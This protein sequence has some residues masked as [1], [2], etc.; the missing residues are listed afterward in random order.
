MG[1]G[2][3]ARVAVLAWSSVLRPTSRLPWGT[4]ALDLGSGA[5]GMAC[6]VSVLALSVLVTFLGT[7]VLN[8][9]DW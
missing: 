8:L 2:E 3:R 7:W 9:V 5:G 4:E 6:A 1:K